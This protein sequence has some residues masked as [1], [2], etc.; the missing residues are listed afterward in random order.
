VSAPPPV[1]SYQCERLASGLIHS[2]LVRGWFFRAELRM[3]GPGPHYDDL[4]VMPHPMRPYVLN[5]PPP[6]WMQSHPL[7]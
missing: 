5:N 1:S 3:H 7:R 4:S 6:Q 2:C